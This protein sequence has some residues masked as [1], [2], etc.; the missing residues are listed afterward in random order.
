MSWKSPPFLFVGAGAPRGIWPGVGDLITRDMAGPGLGCTGQG[1]SH[2]TR[3]LGPCSGVWEVTPDGFTTPSALHPAA[4]NH[5]HP[6][7]LPPT[8]TP[9]ASCPPS[10]ALPTNPLSW[11]QACLCG[12]QGSRAAS[13]RVS[14]GRNGGTLEELI[15]SQA[16]TDRPSSPHTPSSPPDSVGFESMEN[17]AQVHPSSV[18]HGSS[19]SPRVHLMWETGQKE[20]E[21]KLNIPVTCGPVTFLRTGECKAPPGS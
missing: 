12:V 5:H 18:P 3:S 1:A 4:P 13:P 6:S 19:H 17:G 11:P 10:H 7:P 8:P 21:I 16:Q 20:L 9:A 2:L 15:S 14:V